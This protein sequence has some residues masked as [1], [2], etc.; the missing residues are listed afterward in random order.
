[1]GANPFQLLSKKGFAH[2]LIHISHFVSL[3]HWGEGGGGGIV[4]LKYVEK[5]IV[6]VA[7]RVVVWVVRYTYGSHH[8]T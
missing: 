7:S 5:E 6:G 2:K 1:M 3:K 4:V 8:I